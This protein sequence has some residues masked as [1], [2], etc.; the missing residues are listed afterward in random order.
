ML[1]KSKAD[2]SQRFRV[3]ELDFTEQNN[4][5]ECMFHTLAWVSWILELK[6]QQRES[7]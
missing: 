3:Q 1:S 4:A 7:N 5:Y 6:R 2:K